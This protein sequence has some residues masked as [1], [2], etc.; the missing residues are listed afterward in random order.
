MGRGRGPGGELDEEVHVACCVVVGGLG[1]GA[2]DFKTADAVAPA[3][4]AQ[5]VAVVFDQGD[6]GPASGVSLFVG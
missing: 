2:E 5:D 1:G 6:H 4:I 3:E